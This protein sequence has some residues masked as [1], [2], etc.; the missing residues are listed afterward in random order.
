MQGGSGA[1]WGEASD[2]IRTKIDFS[3]VAYTCSSVL[4]F[5]GRGC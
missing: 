1:G 5:C 4:D 2:G 3:A